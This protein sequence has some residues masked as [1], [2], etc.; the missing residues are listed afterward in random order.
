[1]DGLENGGQEGQVRD[2]TPKRALR[3]WDAISNGRPHDI[4]HN[5]RSVFRERESAPV[6]VGCGKSRV[7]QLDCGG[8]EQNREQRSKEARSGERVLFGAENRTLTFRGSLDAGTSDTA[9]KLCLLPVQ[10]GSR[11]S[12]ASKAARLHRCARQ[13]C[14][15]N[16]R[17]F[18]RRGVIRYHGTA[19][20]VEPAQR[21]T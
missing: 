5:R 17:H 4:V 12:R 1:M 3:G 10:R 21:G 15:I 16:T 18:A 9:G 13:P 19:G 2:R 8:L 7:S 6:S 20:R 11:A 14:S